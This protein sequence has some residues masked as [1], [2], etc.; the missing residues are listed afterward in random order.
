MPQSSI[1]Q[2]LK[3]YVRIRERS[4][5]FVEFDF[6]IESP[7]L[8]VELILP[9]LA[10]EEFCARNDVIFMTDGQARD[11]DDQMEKWRYSVSQ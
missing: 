8:F 11:V 5:R 1:P 2:T 6:A 10:F 7:E 3:R 4:E 9:P